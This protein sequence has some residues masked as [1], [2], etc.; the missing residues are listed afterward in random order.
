MQALIEPE[1]LL[2][3]LN[4]EDGNLRL[5]DATY[6]MGGPV[7]PRQVH[8]A[9]HIGNARFFDIDEVADQDSDLP[10]MLPDPASFAAAVAALGISN[11]DT[12][13][14]YDQDGLA[15][16]AARAWWMFR[17]FGHDRVRVLN[18]G[19]P[20]WRAQGYPVNDTPVTP[21]P[22]HFKAALRPE[23]VKSKEDVLQATTQPD[24]QIIDARAAARFGG[25]MPEP[26]AGLRAGH[27]P[28]S[29]NLPYTMVVDGTTGRLKERS[30][31]ESL[32]KDF[33]QK[34]AIASCGSGVTACVLAL[35]FHTTGK[36]DVAIYD[37]SWSEWGRAAAGTPVSTI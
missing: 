18:G 12:V 1:E 23:L 22:G 26:R 15:F 6:A 32:L 17:V 36:A 20:W 35:A 37:G 3:L 16:A 10:H 11:D 28:G 8:A 34:P 4:A 5:L 24:I 14:I 19:L 27:I 31:L 30:E 33:Q 7:D 2:A 25:T 9:C 29:R 21:A 13:V